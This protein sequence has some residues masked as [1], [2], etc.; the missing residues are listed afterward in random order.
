MSCHNPKE[1]DQTPSVAFQVTRLI[2][3]RRNLGHV[4]SVTGAW[5][6]CSWQQVVMET[7][8]SRTVFC[9]RVFGI[10]FCLWV[11]IIRHSQYNDYDKRLLCYYQYVNALSYVLWQTT[12]G[13]RLRCW[14]LIECRRTYCILF[15]GMKCEHARFL[16]ICF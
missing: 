10:C 15:G 7:C 11:R 1:R 13:I 14:F 6:V 2:R 8:H 3:D 9:L 5:R 4:S 16:L 12:V